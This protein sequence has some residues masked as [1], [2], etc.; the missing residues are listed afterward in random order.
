MSERASVQ[1]ES[2]HLWRK[3]VLPIGEVDYRG[4]RT[5]DFTKDYLDRLVE[6]FDEGA[7]DRVPF[8]LADESGQ[9]TSDPAQWRGDVLKLEVVADGLDILVTVTEQGSDVLRRDP[10]LGAAPRIIEDYHRADGRVFPAAI[11][12]ILGTRDP[13]ITGLRPWCLASS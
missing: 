11:Q 13:L 2:G 10:A 8:Q 3:Q 9:H 4:W 1:E 12:H 7:Y 6:A 5:I